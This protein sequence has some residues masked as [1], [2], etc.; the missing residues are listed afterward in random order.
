MKLQTIQEEAYEP[1]AVF[2]LPQQTAFRPA[3]PLNNFSPLHLLT[4]AECLSDPQSRISRAVHFGE[5]VKTQWFNLLKTLPGQRERD[6]ETSHVIM[7]PIYFE[8][9]KS[10]GCACPGRFGNDF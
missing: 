2:W 5:P 7:R 4:R 1:V 9:D 6:R 8:G 10:G 3:K